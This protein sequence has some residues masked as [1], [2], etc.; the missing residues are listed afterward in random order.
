MKQ[1]LFLITFLFVSLNSDAQQKTFTVDDHIYIYDTISKHLFNK[2]NTMN[3]FQNRCMDFSSADKASIF[4][5]IISNTF[6]H[7]RLSFF[8][9]NKCYLLMHTLFDSKGI[10]KEVY[11]IFHNIEIN[12]ELIKEIHLLEKSIIGYRLN[13][14]SQCPD[15]KYF[16]FVWSINFN[17]VLGLTK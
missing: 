6:S 10:I 2:L 4:Y 11:F 14:K 5:P 13:F 9:N 17:K 8:A 1:I 3:K 15:Q 12:K 16:K 7:E